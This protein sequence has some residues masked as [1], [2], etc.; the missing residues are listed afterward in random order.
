M[1]ALA[2]PTGAARRQTPT[3]TADWKRPLGAADL[4]RPADAVA[5]AIA[6]AQAINARAAAR[7]AAADVPRTVV[8]GMPRTVAAITA[9]VNAREMRLLLSGWL[10]RR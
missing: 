7:H 6:R 2:R 5:R 10:A 3:G 9:T 1:R 8:A 4:R